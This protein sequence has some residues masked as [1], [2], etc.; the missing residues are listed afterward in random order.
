MPVKTTQT[1]D[2]AG[3]QPQDNVTTDTAIHETTWGV[4]KKKKKGKILL[5][6]ILT[7]A[8]AALLDTSLDTLVTDAA[9]AD[10]STTT[11]T[12]ATDAA[13]TTT[14]TTT[15]VTDATTSTGTSTDIST[16]GGDSLNM[17]LV[18]AAALLLLIGL[19]VLVKTV[20]DAKTEAKKSNKGGDNNKAKKDAS[21]KSAPAPE[22]KELDELKQQ[23]TEM[24]IITNKQKDMISK[25]TK[26]IKDLQQK[27]QQ[28]ENAKE[29]KIDNPAQPSNLSSNFNSNL[30]VNKLKKDLQNKQTAEKVKTLEMQMPTQPPMYYPQPTV[31]GCYYR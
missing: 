28:N 31:G 5:G 20:Y 1:Q 18:G 25:Q 13:A 4:V 24:M 16:G 19:C 12:N 6:F 3:V 9:A 29:V 30:D 10:A 23:Q 22:N 14:D 27:L 8:G 21:Q 26:C 11:N 7:A 2:I 17:V 15:S